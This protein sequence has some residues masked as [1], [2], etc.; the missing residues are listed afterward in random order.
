MFE[1]ILFILVTAM[2][3]TAAESSAQD[4]LINSDRL[5]QK[6]EIPDQV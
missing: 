5:L 1:R 4:V 6:I 3:L 2:F